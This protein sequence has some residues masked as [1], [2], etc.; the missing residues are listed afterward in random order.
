MQHVIE[1]RH[2]VGAR[3]L[4]GDLHLEQGGAVARTAVVDRRRQH[5]ADNAVAHR[6][7]ADRN[8]GLP[9]SE[10][11]NLKPLAPAPSR[12]TLPPRTAAERRLAARRAVEIA[13]IG[14]EVA[15]RA[16]RIAAGNPSSSTAADATAARRRVGVSHL[17]GDRGR[18]R[19]AVAV[20]HR[21]GRRDR[22]NRARRRSVRRERVLARRLH[23]EQAGANVDRLRV[24]V[25]AK[26]Q[27]RAVDLRHRRAIGAGRKVQLTR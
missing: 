15:D 11:A 12:P 9:L 4:V 25:T 19:V 10:A 26:H 7:Q 3:R 20:G 21:I 27:R 14:V 18:R 1:Q 16:R 22:R 6:L 23:L 5:V 2:L 24:A 17:E 13:E 8:P